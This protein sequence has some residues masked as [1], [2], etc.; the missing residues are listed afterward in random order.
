M[1]AMIMEISLK[2]AKQKN[3]FHFN[4]KTNEPV[5]LTNYFGFETQNG[6]KGIMKINSLNFRTDFYSP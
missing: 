1:N 6:M 2:K 4:T 3:S 5:G